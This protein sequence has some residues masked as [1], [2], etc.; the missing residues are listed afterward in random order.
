MFDGSLDTQWMTEVNY[1]GQWVQV[2][3]TQTHEVHAVD[4]W[5]ATRTQ[6]QCSELKF[7]FSNCVAV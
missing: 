3:F 5:S 6:G 4:L 7:E 1:E 2:N